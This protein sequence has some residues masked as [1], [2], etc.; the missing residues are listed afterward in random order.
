MRTSPRYRR[1]IQ[2]ATR[3]ARPATRCTQPATYRTQP[4]TRRTLSATRRTRPADPL[5]PGCKPTAPGRQPAASRPQPHASSHAPH[6]SSHA[7]LCTQAGDLQAHL[8]KVCGNAPVEV[9]LDMK[10]VEVRPYGVTKANPT[11]NP[12]PHSTP[13]PDQV[14]PYG[15]SKGTALSIIL[16]RLCEQHDLS[17]EAEGTSPKGIAPKGGGDNKHPSPPHLGMPAAAAE[18]SSSRP[19]TP[20]L[21]ASPAPPSTAGGD[22]ATS[23]ERERRVT[24]F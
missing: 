11:P 13:T 10:R 1:E 16:E 5:H 9:G 4:A 2:P 18:E 19:S 21:S 14:R 20:R 3:T 7:P 15:V 8:V 22:G 6:A 24:H 17:E 23:D 12:T